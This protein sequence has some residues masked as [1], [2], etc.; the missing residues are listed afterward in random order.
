MKSRQKNTKWRIRNF[1]FSILLGFTSLTALATNASERILL[2]GNCP[3]HHRSVAQTSV[4]ASLCNSMIFIQNSY[5]DRDITIR[6]ITEEG[7][8]A[9]KQEITRSEAASVTINVDDLMEGEYVL[10]ISDS[11]GNLLQGSF[12]HR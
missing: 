11:A 8:V 1:L 6:I 7:I 4:S 5:P 12:K 10:Q 9:Y 3:T 2:S